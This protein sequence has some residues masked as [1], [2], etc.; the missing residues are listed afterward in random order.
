MTASTIYCS[1][2]GPDGLTNVAAHC[3]A[4]TQSLADKLT[5]IAG[6]ERAFSAPT[7]HEVVLTLPK[8]AAEVLAAL[9]GKDVLGGVSLATDYDMPNAI[10]INATEV[11][12]ESDL[13][14]FAVA[15]KEV[16]A[17]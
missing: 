7:F 14:L 10:L 2:L 11:H 4:N 5:A 6:V 12:S 13:D 8:P 16:L 9:A 1:L 17:A 15:L 3:H